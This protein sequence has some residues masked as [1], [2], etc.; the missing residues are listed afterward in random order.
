M[1]DA[2]IRE[3]IESLEAEEQ[4]LRHEEGEAGEHRRTDIV[5]RDRERL[6]QIRIQLD[7]LWDLLRQ[8]E[9]KRRA[10]EDPDTATLRDPGTVED[11]LG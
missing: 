3:R 6:A 8:R 11:Y 7:Q 4:R 9:A 10:G 1:D 2:E 5:A